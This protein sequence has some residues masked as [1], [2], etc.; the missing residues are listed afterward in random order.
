[1]TRRASDK[2]KGPVP[3]SNTWSF[4]TGWSCLCWTRGRNTWCL[5]QR[6]HSA[7]WG[8]NLTP[9]C[10]N[11]SEPTQNTSRR[12]HNINTFSPSFFLSFFIVLLLIPLFH[13][14][15]HIPDIPFLGCRVKSVCQTPAVLSS[16]GGLCFRGGSG[17]SG[18]FTNSSMCHLHC[19]CEKLLRTEMMA[20]LRHTE[21]M[22]HLPR[23]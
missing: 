3:Q 21:Q 22:G 8:L 23:C 9:C 14:E 16:A 12:K 20:V 5:W 4:G 1:M 15:S 19:W 11:I 10:H 18:L 13:C 17:S 2:L 6:C 7:L